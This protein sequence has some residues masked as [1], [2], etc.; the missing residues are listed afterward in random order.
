MREDIKGIVELLRKRGD[1]SI[2]Y[3][4]GIELFGPGDTD[5]MPDGLHPN[6]DG[7]ELIGKRFAAL[8]FG[9]GGRLLGGRLAEGNP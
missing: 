9:A 7:Y 6:G 2:H 3:R 5:N 4:D 1:A 8:E